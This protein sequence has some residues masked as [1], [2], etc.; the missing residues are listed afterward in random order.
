M[1]EYRLQSRGG[2]GIKTVNITDRNGPVVSLKTV[3]DEED[4]MII[5]A[6]G[7]IIRMNISGISQMGR[8]TQGVR[9]MTMKESNHV[10]TVAVVEREEETEEELLDENGDP[11]VTDEAPE[12]DVEEATNTEDTD[13]NE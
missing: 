1:S 3:T 5:T 9:L 2:K 4:L 12:N 10:A 8:N 11:I 7:I 6:K 13:N